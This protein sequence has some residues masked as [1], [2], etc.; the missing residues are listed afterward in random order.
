[1]I[2]LIQLLFEQSKSQT[3]PSK[4]VAKP[5]SKPI[6]VTKNKTILTVKPD[7]KSDAST[8]TS[9]EK[10]KVKKS[11]AS[12]SNVV[13]FIGGRDE[14]PKY[15]PLETQT[16]LLK[17]GL[18]SQTVLSF[19][20]KYTDVTNAITAY[21][22]NPS[23]AVILFSAGCSS[24]QRFAK[25]M[26]DKSRLFIVEPYAIDAGT[27]KVV[28]GAVNSGVPASNVYIGATTGRG[29]GIVPGASEMPTLPGGVMASHWNALTLIGSKI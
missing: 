26:Q 24:A 17:Q 27:R 29:A 11:D 14:Q 2:K 25:Q 18:G 4:P 16:S 1:M 5:I 8:E 19:R 13:I 3:K 15:K 12:D 21:Q 7:K 10:S 9:L 28:R 6:T 20:Y 23:A 22:E